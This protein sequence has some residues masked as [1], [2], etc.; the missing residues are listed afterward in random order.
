MSSN[1]VSPQQHLQE[2]QVNFFNK[3]KLYYIQL[4]IVSNVNFFYRVPLHANSGF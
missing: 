1:L 2:I 4:I 3:I